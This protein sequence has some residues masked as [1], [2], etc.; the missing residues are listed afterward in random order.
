[1][2]TRRSKNAENE[3]LDPANLDKVV[4]LLEQEKPITKKAACELL[5]IAYNTTRLASII[6][7]H[8]EKKAHTA[9]KRAEK[10]GK[11]ATEAEISFAISEYI[12]GATID[13]ISERLYRSPGLVK[14]IL[15]QYHVPIR[16]RAHD[17]FK[18]ELIPEEAMRERFKV[19]EK[20]YSARY[21][22]TA[23]IEAEQQHK[24]GQWVYRIWLLADKWQQYAYQEAA[25]LASLEHLQKMG[26]TV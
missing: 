17:Y 16:A 1:M 18:P 25:E 14:T 5:N 12:N 2:A 8:K 7:K 3:K 23:R 6:E 26:I 4:E 13:S 15:E 11:P 21:D 22:S 9:A 10:R 24:S 19:G 20:V